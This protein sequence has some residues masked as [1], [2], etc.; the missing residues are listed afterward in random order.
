[1]LARVVGSECPGVAQK[2]KTV[3]AFAQA[4]NEVALHVSPELGA[5]SDHMS[6]VASRFGGALSVFCDAVL[7]PLS[8]LVL[9]GVGKDVRAG[10]VALAEHEV[11]D[12]L[13]QCQRGLKAVFAI[14]ASGVG[15]SE[16]Y[17]KGHWT[18]R[19]VSRFAAET[20]LATDLSHALLQQ[21]FSAC[22]SYETSCGR[23]ED[24][25]LSFDCFQ[26]A[27]VVASLRIFANSKSSH[28][29]CL[30]TVL[31]RISFKWPGHHDISAATISVLRHMA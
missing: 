15:A 23:G 31:R 28:R 14:Y 21:L 13:R 25:K 19:D 10:V 4:L 20:G 2:L 6:R 29:L 5:K 16:P 26:L 17:R 9:K 18:A 30:A 7:L 3:E 24:G 8:S 12:L 1:M 11:A 22:A 27:L